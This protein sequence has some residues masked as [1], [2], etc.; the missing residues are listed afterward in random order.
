MYRKF[1]LVAI[2]HY[3][4][5]FP[6]EGAELDWLLTPAPRYSL[7]SEL[8]RIAEPK[9]GDEN[10][11]EWS[12]PG[13]NRLITVARQIARMKPSTKEGVAMIRELRRRYRES[14]LES[15]RRAS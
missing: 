5:A 1:A 9:S 11:L 4:E 7:L 13:V 15:L 12:A 3:R 2:E 6:V 10:R 14:A 8:G